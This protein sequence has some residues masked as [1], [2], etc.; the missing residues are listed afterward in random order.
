[1]PGPEDS[2]KTA[3]NKQLGSS[4][5]LQKQRQIGDP[6][7]TMCPGCGN[8]RLLC[9]CPKGSGG[10]PS[11][12][13]DNSAQNGEKPNNQTAKDQQYNPLKIHL[14]PQEGLSKERLEALMREGK[15]FPLLM[16]MKAAE[17]QLN[18]IIGWL[19]S[20]NKT[21]PENIAKVGRDPNNPNMLTLTVMDPKYQDSIIKMALERKIIDGQFMPTQQQPS[22]LLRDPLQRIK[23]PRAERV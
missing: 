16:S 1:M 11:G 15:V 19:A 9:K 12:G 13:G 6:T 7:G 22:S 14:V 8:G 21:K 23:D 20:M 4:L 10:G 3:L 2:Q 18:S 5:A 17:D